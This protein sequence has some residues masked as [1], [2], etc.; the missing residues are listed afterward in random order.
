MKKILFFLSLVVLVNCGK[1]QEQEQKNPIVTTAC[2]DVSQINTVRV[3]QST[4]PS[5]LK[6]QGKIICDLCLYSDIE[7]NHK[8]GKEIYNIYLKK[9]WNE[10][11]ANYKKITWLDMKTYTQSYCYEKYLT[12]RFNQNNNDVLGFPTLEDFTYPTVDNIT[13]YSIPLIRSIALNHNICDEDLFCF[14]KAKIN[15]KIRIVFK[16]SDKEGNDIGYYDISNE[17]TKSL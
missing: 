11:T 15:D 4:L 17:P 6:T 9:F 13:N 14:T 7:K 10:A 16:L 8:I 3:D 5:R 1:C 12:F 2:N